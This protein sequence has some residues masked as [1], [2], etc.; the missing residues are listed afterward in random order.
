MKLFIIL[1]HELD[2]NRMNIYHVCTDPLVGSMFV[3]NVF[4]FRSTLFQHG[5]EHLFKYFT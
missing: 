1:T 5:I 3:F 4:G 2:K